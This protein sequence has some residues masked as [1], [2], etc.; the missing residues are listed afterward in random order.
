MQMRA[1]RSPA[2]VLPG[3]SMPAS[4]TRAPSAAFVTPTRKVAA[5]PTSSS[6][7]GAEWAFTLGR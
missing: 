7:R 1:M 3:W 6:T 5:R 4:T 2:S